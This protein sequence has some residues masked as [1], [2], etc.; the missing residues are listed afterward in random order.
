MSWLL[1]T[2]E[3]SKLYGIMSE[4]EKLSDFNFID[5]YIIGSFFH[6]YQQFF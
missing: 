5:V 4:K 3:L 1:E 2:D 6:I